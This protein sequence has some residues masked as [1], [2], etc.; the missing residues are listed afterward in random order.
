[1]ADVGRECV[2]LAL[3]FVQANS[4]PATV[5]KPELLVERFLELSGPIR[6]ERSSRIITRLRG[7]E[8]P[9]NVRGVHVALYLAECDWRFG[10]RAIGKVDAVQGVLPPLVSQA[11]ICLALVLD[12]TITIAVAIGE[13][14]LQS[15]VGVR[16]QRVNLL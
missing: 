6:P 16:D 15:A 12:E 5:G 13:Y 14:P 4:K 11:A 10:E 9:G 3:V 1:M 2:D 8:R 7:E